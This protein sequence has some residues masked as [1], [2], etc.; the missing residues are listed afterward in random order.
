[1]KKMSVTS[2]I[3]FVVWAVLITGAFVFT[4]YKP[5]AQF[6]PYI[7]WLTVGL[8]AYTGRRLFKHHKNFNQK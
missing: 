2:S 7:T 4:G 6:V 1:M 3:A 8:G 5:S